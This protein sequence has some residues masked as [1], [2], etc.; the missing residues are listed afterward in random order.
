[1]S[2]YAGAV[3]AIKERFVEAWT[4]TPI[5]FANQD[6]PQE[7]WPPASGAWIYFEVIGNGSDMRSIGVPGDHMWTYRGNIFAHVFVPVGYGVEEPQRL[8]VAAGE[9][10]RAATFYDDGQGSKV[11]CIS[12]QVDG[13]GSDAD[14]GNWFRMTATV[15]F[16]YYHRG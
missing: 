4:E 14:Q 7:P 3:A 8:A 16:N 15:P 2:D 1:M 5:A 12:P 10:F 9:I 13:G 6:P 11:V